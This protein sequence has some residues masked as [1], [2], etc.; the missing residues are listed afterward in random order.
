MQRAD[1]PRSGP[2]PAESGQPAPSASS[3]GQAES[4]RTVSFESGL[5]RLARIVD[6]LEA[7][8]LGLVE[9]IDAYEQGITLIRHLH[10]QL[11]VCEQRVEILAAADPLARG[12]GAMPAT[13]EPPVPTGRPAKP[14]R[15][16]P[17]SS[18]RSGRTRRLPGMDDSPPG[19]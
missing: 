3:A 18:G 13:Q 11:S 17:G 2:G 4:A 8:E 6:Q 15:S 9:S 1:E 5:E 12:D 19:V 7:G 16:V 14:D 10:H